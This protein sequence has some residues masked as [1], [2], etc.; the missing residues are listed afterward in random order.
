MKFHRCSVVL[1]SVLKLVFESF[2]F[3]EA[4]K[5]RHESYIPKAAI[6]IMIPVVIML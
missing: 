6:M 3:Y 4:L 2:R 1:G 5:G